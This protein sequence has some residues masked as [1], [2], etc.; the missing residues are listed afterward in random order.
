MIVWISARLLEILFALR[1]LKV[2][3]DLEV[4]P[5]V[6]EDHSSSYP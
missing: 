3:Y 2:M 6:W 1:W 5:V 4:I